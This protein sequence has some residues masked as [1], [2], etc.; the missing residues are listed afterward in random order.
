MAAVLIGISLGLIGGGGSILTVPVLVYLFGVDATLATSYSLFI[1]GATSLVGAYKNYTKGLVDI[2]TAL[3]FGAA[4]ITTVLLTRRFVIPLV[5]DTIWTSGS[6]AITKSFL[7]MVLFAAL[8]LLASF[9]MIRGGKK[10]TEPATNDGGNVLP[11]LILYGIGIGL[12]TGLLGAGGGFLLIPALVLLLRLP[13]KNAVGTSLFII[14]LNSL[15]GFTGDLGRATVDWTFLLTLTAISVVG[16]IVGTELSKK[17]PGIK[18]KTGFG[19]FVMIMAVYILI[20]E[21]FLK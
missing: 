5:P 18:L 3:L 10:I 21:F 12:V 7:T 19:W 8:M 13:M 14:A 2:K 4:S 11:S 9:S 15:I 20:K 16:I 17:I 6:V 1:V